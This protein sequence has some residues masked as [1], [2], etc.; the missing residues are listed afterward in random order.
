MIVRLIKPRSLRIVLATKGAVL[1]W[2]CSALTAL[3][4]GV[5]EIAGVEGLR[6]RKD[7]EDVLL[8][9][10]SAPN[11]TFAVMWRSNGNWQTPW[12]LLASQERA[13]AGVNQTIFSDS[14]ALARAP[15]M[16]RD[17]DLANFYRVF[18]IPDFWLDVEG[19]KFSGGPRN[20]GEDFLP[21]YYGNQEKSFF[22]PTVEL[23]VDGCSAQVAETPEEDIQ[24]VNFGSVEKPRWR[25]TAGIWFHHDD[26]TNGEHTLQLVADLTL[27]NTVGDNTQTVTLTNSPKRVWI[28]HRA[29][30]KAQGTQRLSQTSNAPSANTWWG[31]R[32]G[33]QFVRKRLSSEE[34]MAKAAAPKENPF[35]DQLE[36][37]PWKDSSQPRTIPKSSMRLDLGTPRIEF[38]PV[39]PEY[40]NAV[41]Q[42]VLPYI[43][44]VV[45]A[46]GIQDEPASA[47]QVIHCSIP[48]NGRV[49]A[50]IG[51]ANGW[52][53]AFSQG[54]IRTIQSGHSYS[55]LQDP[56]QILLFFG[57]LNMPRG[58]A[59]QLARDTLGKLGIPLESVFAEQDPRVSGP[60]QVGANTVPHY[61][62]QWPDPR[63]PLSVDIEVNGN[64]KRV[65][66]IMVRSENLEKPPP[67]I[68]TAPSRAPARPPRPSV[69]PEYA[70]QLMPLVLS[71]IETYAEKLA[72]QVPRP[73]TT[74]QVE[75]FR[76]TDNGGWPHCEIELSSGWRFVYRNN[77]VNGYDAPD[78]LFV[79]KPR[80]IVLKHFL[81]DS[82]M[83]Q[84]EA[85]QLVRDTI[86]KLDYPT[87]LVHM[88]G[89]PQTHKAAV[90]GIPRLQFFWYYNENDDLQSTVRAEVDASTRQLKS[91]YY[92]DRAYWNHPPPIS[93]PIVLP[94]TAT[95]PTAPS[96]PPAGQLRPQRPISNIVP[97]R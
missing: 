93:A 22:R 20:P 96:A 46:L 57:E 2:L 8:T 48:P 95:P 92:D 80:R 51:L 45:K 88:E 86:A 68:S 24:R 52:V 3:S 78:A 81:A 23:L 9:W 43:S 35:D 31:H 39:S 59:V 28:K 14:G 13:P 64:A 54:Y 58:D 26:L 10:P 60:F 11:E 61:Y 84:A 71:A 90:S 4:E 53:F 37:R 34:W 47:T 62:V 25:Y 27:N 38:V 91:L 44:H 89:E 5:V 73:I 74:N 75:V 66:R 72:L 49:E 82:K 36:P 6:L 30:E 97:P 55:V 12:V 83:T 50:E 16:A 94:A 42:A 18:V 67:E 21:F 56:E 1:L 77:M 29:D 19:V 41:L 17:Q 7:R 69:N 32:L 87:N 65:E 85:A 15:A 70:R 33:S 40:S 79:N 76:V 63:G